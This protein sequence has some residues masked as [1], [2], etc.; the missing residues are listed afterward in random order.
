MAQARGEGDREEEWVHDGQAFI[1][2]D[3]E[4]REQVHLSEGS[5]ELSVGG[6]VSSPKPGPSKDRTGK[7]EE[8]PSTM[9]MLN[10]QLQLLQEQLTNQAK[11]QESLRRQLARAVGTGHDESDGTRQEAPTPD[12]CPPRTLDTVTK[13]TT[14]GEV[15]SSPRSAQTLSSRPNE[16]SCAGNTTYGAPSVSMMSAIDV[17][18]VNK[19]GTFKGASFTEYREFMRLFD[20]HVGDTNVSGKIKLDYLVSLCSSSIRRL[21]SGADLLNDENGYERARGILNR[22]FGNAQLHLEELVV[23][24][25]EGP[26][27]RTHDR[28]ALTHLTDNYFEALQVATASQQLG[29]LE[30]SYITNKIVAR[31]PTTMME[32]YNKLSVSTS[33]KLDRSVSGTEFYEFLEENALALANSRFIHEKPEREPRTHRQERS[34]EPKRAMGLVTTTEGSR[35]PC[36]LCEGAHPLASCKRFRTMKAPDRLAYAQKGAICFLCLKGRHLA[37]ECKSGFLPCDIDGCGRRHSRWLHTAAPKSKGPKRRAEELDYS[38]EKKGG[39]P[40]GSKRVKEELHSLGAMSSRM[41][42]A[43][44]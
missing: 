13:D 30:F 32:D 41:D 39:E 34:P 25:A 26:K 43:G 3:S 21:L 4:D 5:R 16:W 9:E 28:R 8:R 18:Q 17:Q 22:R 10:Q 40:S 33:R 37:A 1:G 7:D 44:Q 15:P 14:P 31:L 11:M 35:P 29:A 38:E 12:R 42:N 6:R 24:L 2:S 23:G 36:F 19:I 20:R 27:I